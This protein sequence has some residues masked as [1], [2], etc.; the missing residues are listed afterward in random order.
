MACLWAK[1][2]PKF[3]ALLPPDGENAKPT[4]T[5]DERTMRKLDSVM[6][7]YGGVVAD[8]PKTEQAKSPEEDAFTQK[9][10]RLMG[11]TES[12]KSGGVS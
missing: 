11:V 4:E 6:F 10:W 12:D 7:Q 9:M 1:D 5:E 8:R 2:P 3:E